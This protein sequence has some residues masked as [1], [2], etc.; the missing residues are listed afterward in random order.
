M[1]KIT[2]LAAV[3]GLSAALAGGA[4]TQGAFAQTGGGSTSPHAYTCSNSGDG[5]NHVVSCVGKITDNDVLKNV[6]VNVKDINVLS[7]NQLKDLEVALVNVADNKVNL[8]VLIQKN[9]LVTTT[10]N[11]YLSKFGIV[12]NVLK[13][14]AVI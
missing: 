13:V 3:A 2:R 5:I 7:D 12:I 6:T 14:L 10:V 1:R 9:E 11:T 8:P 4:L